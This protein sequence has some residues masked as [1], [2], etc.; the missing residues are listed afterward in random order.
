MFLRIP[1]TMIIP[2]ILERL[3][4]VDFQDFLTAVF[5]ENASQLP[6]QNLCASNS[7]PSTVDCVD[8]WMVEIT[9]RTGTVWKG[10]FQVEFTEERSGNFNAMRRTEQRYGELRFALNTESAAIVLQTDVG[11]EN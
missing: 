1:T 9:E 5:I 8:I 4:D 7:H 2:E 11:S 3:E 10:N 6:L